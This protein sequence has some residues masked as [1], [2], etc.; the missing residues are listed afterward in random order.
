MVAIEVDLFWDISGF[1]G[2]FRI[3]SEIF[4][5]FWNISGFSGVFQDFRDFSGFFWIFGILRS[6][7]LPLKR[8]FFGYFRIFWILRKYLILRFLR[9]FSKMCII[10]KSL[11]TRR[12]P[13]ADVIA[14]TTAAA[15]P[16]RRC[17]ASVAESSAARKLCGCGGRIVE[18]SLDVRNSG[19][20]GGRRRLFQFTGR[21]IRSRRFEC[22]HRQ[23]RRHRKRK[24]RKWKSRKCRKWNCL[25]FPAQ[26]L[27]GNGPP[28]SQKPQEL[29]PSHHF[30]FQVKFN[31]IQV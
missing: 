8:I 25:G 10:L 27:L 21:T 24:C 29:S 28:R 5:I 26:R 3:F 22:H 19:G 6:W 13:G 15:D 23:S 1:P 12:W 16:L 20:P 30:N 9:I 11:L 4:R 17:H 18:G 31:S 14:E 7:W 2:F